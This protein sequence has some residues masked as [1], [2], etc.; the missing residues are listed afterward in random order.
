ML[1]AEMITR[2]S[3]AY[4]TPTNLLCHFNENSLE[5]NLKNLRT[6]V[7]ISWIKPMGHAQ[8][9]I[10]RPIIKQIIIII[11]I[12][13]ISNDSSQKTV[14]LLKVVPSVHVFC[15]PEAISVGMS[16]RRMGISGE[17]Q[18]EP[19]KVRFNNITNAN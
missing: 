16:K 12:V 5:L 18:Y 9:H 11:A 4:F 15:P 17:I 2:R 19:I 1:I 7:N 8:P 14:K 3:T 6:F 13:K 10:A